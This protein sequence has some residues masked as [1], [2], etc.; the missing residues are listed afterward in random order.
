MKKLFIPITAI[1]LIVSVVVVQMTG[2]KKD[3]V[4][5]PK[6]V[7]DVKGTY[8]GTSLA[9]TS[10]SSTLTYKLL[11]NN[12]AVGSETPKG[13]ATTFGG[14]RNTC[15]SVILSVYYTKNASYYLLEGKLS[16]DKTTIS[17]TFKNLTDNSDYG[18]FTMSK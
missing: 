12:F 8:S 9:S 5:P 15:D 17:G 3:P 14:Y 2:C 11:D 1:T 10:V 13:T 16:N 18:T 6:P 4:Q 7:C